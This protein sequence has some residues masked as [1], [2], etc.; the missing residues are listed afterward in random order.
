LAVQVGANAAPKNSMSTSFW[1]R[2]R[3]RLMFSPVVA[4]SVKSGAGLPISSAAAGGT[5]ISAPVSTSNPI[6]SRTCI[7]WLLS[8]G[9]FDDSTGPLKGDRADLDLQ[10]A[11]PSHIDHQLDPGIRLDGN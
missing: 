8:W 7:S 6:S 4:G 3:R 1:P 2:N 10:R 9:S 11:R 5:S